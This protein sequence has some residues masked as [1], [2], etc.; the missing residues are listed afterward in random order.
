MGLGF[1]SIQSEQKKMISPNLVKK[2][3]ISRFHLISPFQ[4]SSHEQPKPFLVCIFW[5]KLLV[6]FEV[7]VLFAKVF[8]LQVT[9]D[10]KITTLQNKNECEKSHAQTLQRRASG[11]SSPST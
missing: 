8:L 1:D 4:Y 5:S 3:K 7:F 2:F 11:M 9:N 10:S 6:D